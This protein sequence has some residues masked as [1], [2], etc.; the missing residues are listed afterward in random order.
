MGG[1][2]SGKGSGGGQGSG[3]GKGGKGGKGDRRL[4]ADDVVTGLPT[5]RQRP[6]DWK[7]VDCHEWIFA[8]HQHCGFCHAV[9]PRNPQTW[10]GDKSAANGKQQQPN[11]P[12]RHV[13]QPK[14]GSGKGAGKTNPNPQLAEAKKRYEM[15]K[16]WHD[17]AVEA[18]EEHNWPLQQVETCKQ[19]YETLLAQASNGSDRAGYLRRLYVAAREVAVEFAVSGGIDPDDMPE[20]KKAYDL[21]QAAASGPSAKGSR[22]PVT[23][24]GSAA[25]NTLG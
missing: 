8:R 6:G 12:S 23:Q 15:V 10:V 18:G 22:P 2:R 13:G 20:V 9:K 16:T 7:C 5:S 21:W 24:E 17:A 19:A 14:K 4:P 25:R 1:N 11:D 3:D